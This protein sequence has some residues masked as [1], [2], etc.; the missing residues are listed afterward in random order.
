[1]FQSVVARIR[2]RARPAM[3][4][5]SETQNLR[6]TVGAQ[7]IRRI[8]G[9][10]PR[11]IKSWIRAEQ[12]RIRRLNR[13][14]QW[15]I[16]MRANRGICSVEIASNTVGFFS[17]LTWCLRILQYCDRHHLIPD[18]RMTGESYRDR[19]R[20]ENWLNYYFD[21]TTQMSPEELSRKVR[22]TKKMCEDCK[23]GFCNSS[24][25]CYGRLQPLVPEISLEEGARIFHKYL[26]PN[27][28][29]CRIVDDFWTAIDVDGPVVGVH[30]R[31]TDHLEE[32]PR[33]SYE[34]CR[35]VL[36]SY[37]QS[38]KNINA[39]F[40][41][42]DEQPFVDFIK[43]SVDGALPIYSR[44]DYYRSSHGV[45][46]SEL[47][48][49]RRESDVSPVFRTAVGEGGYEKGEDALVNS[50]LLSNC[51][52]LIRTTSRLSAWASIFNLDLRVILLNRP[53]EDALWYPETEVVTRWNTEYVPERPL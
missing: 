33:V 27:A 1:M 30:F 19:K 34:H 4:D 9:V 47:P 8:S 46:K 15:A 45:D 28:H 16:P 39:I 31:G 43:Q 3:R 38:H 52:T 36:E 37:L 6:S 42:S 25:R 13:R 35:H 21:W 12:L 7:V 11:P 18:I 14:L 48:H 32:A 53:Y 24:P 29:I 49:V 23:Y 2:G 17:Q 20:G 40:V 5:A 50:L 26:R 44:N 22:Y 10:T 51:S 41:A